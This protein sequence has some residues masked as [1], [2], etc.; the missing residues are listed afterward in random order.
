MPNS[1]YAEIISLS[2]LIGYTGGHIVITS[3]RGTADFL[4][5]ALKANINFIAMRTVDTN[6]SKLVI[7]SEGC[8]RL[9]KTE[10]LLIHEGKLTKAFSYDLTDDMIREFCDKLS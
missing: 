3:Q 10:S 1:V 5:G 7:G 2:M 8:E 9:H 6:N 4:S